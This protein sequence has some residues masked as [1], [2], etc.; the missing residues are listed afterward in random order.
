LALIAEP[1]GS[2]ANHERQLE[3]VASASETNRVPFRTEI[4]DLKHCVQLL[5]TELEIVKSNCE[6]GKAALVVG[7]ANV[8]G[9]MSETLSPITSHVSICERSLE[10]M[11]AKCANESE[12]LVLRIENIEGTVSLLVLNL[13]GRS[14]SHYHQS[15]GVCPY[16]KQVWNGSARHRP[17]FH[18][19]RQVQ[20][21]IQIAEKVDKSPGF[22]NHPSHS[23]QSNF[24]L[25]RPNHVRESFRIL[26]GNTGEMFTTKELSQLLQS[27]F[28]MIPGVLC[29]MSLISLLTR[30][31]A[32]RTSQASGFAG[33]SAKC[34]SA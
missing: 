27:R 20:N 24:R 14:Q 3:N 12:T 34:A 19:H 30:I 7:I 18:F 23:K 22:Q 13:S 6:C 26:L 11:K 8:E 31:S 33:I 9:K 15:Q 4:D 5:Q 25:R 1:E 2:I 17:H 21:Q 16:V 28:M 29:G 10:Q 32:Q